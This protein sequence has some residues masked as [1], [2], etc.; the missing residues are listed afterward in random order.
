MSEQN[1]E[2]DLYSRFL[3]ENDPTPQPLPNPVEPSDKYTDWDQKPVTADIYPTMA[4]AVPKHMVMQLEDP[5][6]TQQT[7]LNG[8][9]AQWRSWARPYALPFVA[10]EEMNMAWGDGTYDPK[11]ID[12][13]GE[14]MASFAQ[15]KAQFNSKGMTLDIDQREFT[16]QL[17]RKAR[18]E[19]GVDWKG[20]LKPADEDQL[21]GGMGLS[22]AV[23][24][25]RVRPDLR[26]ESATARWEMMYDV[27]KK[28]FP[29]YEGDL[30]TFTQDVHQLENLQEGR[31]N[32]FMGEGHEA[33]DL[34]RARELYKGIAK[35]EW[36]GDWFELLDVFEPVVK[37]LRTTRTQSNEALKW[38]RL[39]IGIPPEMFVK[40]APELPVAEIP[41]I[42]KPLEKFVTARALGVSHTNQET[43][44]WSNVYSALRDTVGGPDAEQILGPLYQRA[45]PAMNTQLGGRGMPILSRRDRWE[46]VDASIRKEEDPAT[47]FR[48]LIQGVNDV[49][50]D[51]QKAWFK[52]QLDTRHAANVVDQRAALLRLD[53]NEPQWNPDVAHA[54]ATQSRDFR[55]AQIEM[56]AQL[57]KAL[58]DVPMLKA[59]TWAQTAVG[60]LVK[61]TRIDHVDKLI[62]LPIGEA[63]LNETLRNGLSQLQQRY[64]DRAGSLGDY[65]NRQI[66]TETAYEDWAKVY[67]EKKLLGQTGYWD[68]AVFTGGAV[69]AGF[70][71]MPGFAVNS[72]AEFLAFSKVIGKYHSARTPVGAAMGRAG[73]PAFLQGIVQ[74]GMDPIAPGAAFNTFIGRTPEVVRRLGVGERAFRE[75]LKSVNPEYASAALANATKWR[76]VAQREGL[77]NNANRVDAAYATYAALL[78]RAEAGERI[79]LQ[80]VR[81]FAS[82][83]AGESPE[84]VKRMFG[85][86]QRQGESYHARLSQ[87]TYDQEIRDLNEREAIVER[88]F[89]TRRQAAEAERALGASEKMIGRRDAASRDI[90]LTE[91]AEFKTMSQL[92]TEAY[93]A[94]VEGKFSAWRDSV[95]SGFLSLF[96]KAFGD[97]V[98]ALVDRR[99][100]MHDTQAHLDPVAMEVAYRLGD[101]HADM[102]TV[103]GLY[104]LAK[105]RAG[106][107]AGVARS[108]ADVAAITLKWQKDTQY[109]LAWNGNAKAARN[110]QPGIDALTE[111]LKLYRGR[112]FGAEELVTMINIERQRLADKGWARVTY[113]TNGNANREPINARSEGL[114]VGHTTNLSPV[115]R[116]TVNAYI[117]DMAVFTP[118]VI[119]MHNMSSRVHGIATDTSARYRYD[120]AMIAKDQRALNIA[121]NHYINNQF[122]QA[123]TVLGGAKITVVQ[124]DASV[125]KGIERLRA[126]I[127]KH[128]NK[129]LPASRA[130]FHAA[131]EKIK[132]YDVQPLDVDLQGVVEQVR[133]KVSEFRTLGRGAPVATLA[134]ININPAGSVYRRVKDAAGRTWT[135]LVPGRSV[136]ELLPLPAYEATSRMMG[137]LAQQ[138]ESRAHEIKLLTTAVKE[139]SHLLS[140]ADQQ[141]LAAVNTVHPS[142]WPANLPAR[143]REIALM[144]SEIQTRV[145]RHARSVGEISSQEADRLGAGDYDDRFYVTRE[146]RK[147]LEDR[148]IALRPDTTTESVRMMQSA[149]LMRFQPATSTNRARVV[150]RDWAGNEGRWTA[151]E[152]PVGVDARTA[153]KEAGRWLADMIQ[154]KRIR[155]GEYMPVIKATTH[156]S[157]VMRG[158]MATNPELRADSM[159]KLH[160]EVLRR[161]FFAQIAQF[162]GLVRDSLDSIPITERGNWEHVKGTEWGTLSGRHVSKSLIRQMNSWTGYTH[163]LDSIVKGIQESLKV[164]GVD[165]KSL[166]VIDKRG[167][168]G[169]LDYLDKQARHNYMMGNI[170]SW[171][172]NTL[173]NMVGSIAAGINV[174]SPKYWRDFSEGFTD[175]YE[176]FTRTESI[177]ASHRQGQVRDSV[178]MDF[179]DAIRYGTLQRAADTP[180]KSV[181]SN[182]HGIAR[183]LNAVQKRDQIELSRLVQQ[184]SS[185]AEIRDR[186]SNELTYGKDVTESQKVRLTEMVEMGERMHREIQTQVI[187]RATRFGLLHE[188]Q[189]A[190]SLEIQKGRA[191]IVAREAGDFLAD[192]DRSVIRGVLGS[193]YSQIDA[194]SKW[195]D[196]RYL[197]DV[198]GLTQSEA[199]E[200]VARYKQNFGG[201]APWIRSLKDMKLLGA[202]VPGFPAEAARNLY[203]SIREDPGRLVNILAATAAINS[204]VMFSRN[205]LPSD[206]FQ[207]GGDDSN[208]DYAKRMFMTL[209]VPAPDGIISFDISQ[210]MSLAAFM[211]PTGALRPGV[212]AV[213]KWMESKAGA[214]SIPAQMVLNFATSFIVNTPATSMLEKN[215]L[216]IDAFSGELIFNKSTSGENLARFGKDV[217]A[218]LFPATL[219]RG[220]ESANDYIKGPSSLITKYNRSALDRIARAAGV[221]VRELTRNAANA[222]LIVRNAGPKI[223]AEMYVDA[224]G[225]DKA[226]Y[227]RTLFRLDDALMHNDPVKYAA[228][229]AAALAMKK[230]FAENKRTIG[231]RTVDYS[232]KDPEKLRELIMADV[233]AN[234]NKTIESLPVDRAVNT[235]VQLIGGSATANDPAVVHIIRT[236]TQP[237]YTREKSDT[238]QILDGAKQAYDVSQA[239]IDP[240]RREMFTGVFIQLM[241]RL[242]TIQQNAQTP[243]PKNV[244]NTRLG[245][246]PGY[247]HELVSK[248][249][250]L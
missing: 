161:E 50:N 42:S 21:L 225:A 14:D 215:V 89:A 243:L 101:Q 192:P 63:M 106:L 244:L 46:Q 26:R 213:N 33:I 120:N 127:D 124:T 31:K 227:T 60:N 59:V 216:G 198:K 64:S 38:Q 80:S 30:H 13:I 223:M 74:L 152:F 229:Y 205:M 226:E 45:D 143:V 160:S 10:V 66:G 71:Q 182:V 105:Q 27:F 99:I 4:S 214:F 171:L 241:N 207:M 32:G 240:A 39:G 139:G 37:A 224:M 86:F 28:S 83:L 177:A 110:M 11:V 22:I 112:A 196:I 17:A 167:K 85:P 77:V 206:M 218:Y 147:Q 217:A 8:I 20:K 222:Q 5:D 146:Y 78:S 233:G 9:G 131:M 133:R 58:D 25:A 55:A 57:A 136:A 204:G 69:L 194:K 104:Q 126:R 163:V 135:R 111:Q 44:G 76:E 7:I 153:N 54:R 90:T 150:Y 172:N 199:F 197:R 212:A 72:P 75:G 245:E 67:A 228:T 24:N 115:Q 185:W 208:F 220:A 53:M 181:D 107:D 87:V 239:T 2:L 238:V 117:H 188:I 129:L 130:K 186:A 122:L 235:L 249:L 202:F 178:E 1:E 237:L 82:Q 15:L 250:G 187:A 132:A 144:Q 170:G 234:I 246:M 61:M 43:Q 211:Q 128:S 175:L 176:N 145:I 109:Q 142:R 236:L 34:N 36:E 134:D 93:N 164:A 230:E 154:R 88:G 12:G 92:G 195:A 189:A 118:Q 138:T 210:W 94:Y 180:G 40:G 98:L 114:E 140:I 159:S 70:L 200:R 209:M 231:G 91:A 56:D 191:G 156:R 19:L 162:G 141:I 158:L 79:T 148:G 103:Q 232:V 3:A 183:A 165:G 100:N 6:H 81:D 62:A 95:Q 201:V 166:G 221:N 219:V 247:F 119:G 173:G 16:E 68:D 29:G 84:V 96:P 190:G 48:L 169:A 102:R 52:E 18:N 49:G 51:A 41:F 248:H 151:R 179:V 157:E 47:R 73:V 155:K 65:I 108:D 113:D 149:P 121:E 23:A 203:N 137:M 35:K 242:R 168:E 193:R 97:E 116:Q 184:S 125:I 174:A 123:K